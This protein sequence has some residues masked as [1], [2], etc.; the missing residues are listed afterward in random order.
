MKKIAIIGGGVAAM[1][2]AV[3]ALRANGDVTLFAPYGLGGLV[4]TIDRIDNYPS[5]AQVEGWQ[6]VQNFAAQAKGLGLRP[7]RERVLSL[8]K[9]DAGFCVKTD[10]NE[11]LFDSVVVA[12]GTAHNKL[13]FESKWVG[14][15]VSYC[16]TCDGNFF[17]GKSVAVVG[18]GRQAVREAS[19]LADVVGDVTVV[20]PVAQLSVEQSAVDE[21]TSK[22]NVNVL[23]NVVATDIVGDDCVSGLQI[24]VD[25]Q[26]ETLDVAAVFVA[27]G[28]TPASEFVQIDGVKDDKGF[29]VIDS[30]AET[31]VKGLFAAGDVTNGPLKQIVTAAADG[32]KAGLFA[33][34]NN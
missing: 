26:P 2:A 3:Y 23:Y 13:G 16:A 4:A 28:Q 10:K 33:L 17:R 8:I 15:G 34:K 32:A 9:G 12:S 27:V 1:S 18:G 7:I 30:R 25:G 19:Y 21:L 14:H 29:L 22:N 11:Y 24:S 20:C 5:Y 31:P 6:L